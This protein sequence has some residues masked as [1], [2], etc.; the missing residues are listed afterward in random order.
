MTQNWPKCP[1]AEQICRHNFDKIIDDQQNIWAIVERL[2]KIT[3]TILEH[4]SKNTS[5]C[6]I[7]VW[8]RLSES[9]K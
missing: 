8:E 7:F 5:S 4:D 1:A 2:D 9:M 3:A 6:L